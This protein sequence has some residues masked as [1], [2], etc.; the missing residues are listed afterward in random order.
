M[1]TG[2]IAQRM[3]YYIY[4]MIPFT[5]GIL[6]LIHRMT[7][8][9]GKLQGQTLELKKGLNILQ[10]P[11]ET[12]KSTWCAFLLSM[13][14]GINSRERERAGFIPDKIR[15][16][17]WS[18]T[19]MS[20]RL[21]CTAG[22]TALTLTRATRRQTAPMGDF[23]AVYTGTGDPAP[24]LSGPSCGEMLL[25]V[26][27]EIF[28]RSAFIRQS[29]LAISQ[30]A[31]LERRIA[32]LITSGEEEVSFSEANDLLKKQL[33]RR[34]HNKTGRIPVLEA[35]LASIRQQISRSA[36]LEQQLRDTNR[37]IEELSV[38][39]NRLAAEAARHAQWEL[40][41]KRQALEASAGSLRQ[42]EIRAAE[43]RTQLESAGT[44]ESE[45]IIRLR[46]AIVN[47]E[48][49]RRQT[50]KARTARDEAAKTLLRVEANLSESPF[51]GET[52]EAARKTAAA[53]PS[54]RAPN[55]LFSILLVVLGAAAGL[56]VSLAATGSSAALYIA[57]GGCVGLLA[58][59][60]EMYLRISGSRKKQTA[61]LR[62]LG[63]D[64]QEELN[65]ALEHYLELYTAFESAQA[66][67]N[68]KSAAAEALYSTLSS[69]EQAILLEIRRFA[70]TAFDIPTADALLRECA[71][72]RRQLT[73]AEAATEKARMYHQLLQ[74]EPLPAE[75]AALDPHMAP[76]EREKAVV[77]AELAQ[78]RGE[79]AQARSSAD[80]LSGQLHAAGDP[81]A[82]HS[83]AEQLRQQ[84][85][86][87][88]DEYAAIQLAMDALEHANTTIQN[89]F[90][91]ELGRRTA[92]IF[93]ELT[94][95]RYSGVVLDRSF[96]LSAEPL[97]D[98]VYRDA[99]LLSAGT[100]DQ[101]YLAARLAICNLALPKDRALPIILD[102]ALANF[103]DERCAAAL[104][105]LKREAEHRQIL[106]FT[107]HSREAEFFANDSEVFIQRLT[108]TA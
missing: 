73:E 31:S 82:L 56:A 68:A 75:A 61:Y 22:D 2:Q 81:V 60:L 46:G 107:C 76:P 91:P 85:A 47:L 26:N 27:R 28:E 106:L 53:V 7:A 74:Q 44:P 6:L 3:L 105:W 77:S 21:D 24:D 51:T 65:A 96:H 86:V 8:N 100:A 17:P 89:R 90:S 39:E 63:A 80:R 23:K 25:G 49:T 97:G 48:T 98:A 67:L 78:I 33:N 16:A 42:A 104:R 58:A 35:E 70:P 12:G 41:Q 71:A 54:L 13:F 5:G 62:A 15:Y 103:D 11:N 1:G 64:T 69:N 37:R 101:L 20:G 92:E 40:L 99:G 45:T 38:C 72:H 87:L 29:G 4:I 14:Y 55:P 88:E 50:E 36:E 84:I 19:A 59:L 43:L 18:G 94:D 93:G 34:R 32:S 9:F 95:G 79:L 52:P 66:D 57:A 10:A 102:D 108:E 83:G 30:D